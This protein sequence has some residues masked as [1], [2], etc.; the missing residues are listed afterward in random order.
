VVVESNQIVKPI[1][2]GP[3]R[4]FRRL[5]ADE[6][7]L[8]FEGSTIT[9]P[10]RG[11]RSA[12]DPWMEEDIKLKAFMRLEV[13]APYRNNLGTREFQ[14]IIRDW[15][16]HGKSPMLNRLFY[17][18]PRGKWTG[19]HFRPAVVTFNVANTYV[20]EGDDGRNIFG[21][22]RNLEIRNLTS[23]HLRSWTQ[24]PQT[25]MGLVYG[26]PANRIYWQIVDISKFTAEERKPFQDFSEG[27]APLLVFYKSPVVRFN[28]LEV[29]FDLRDQRTVAESLLAIA[30]QTGEG[31][32]AAGATFVAQALSSAQFE[33]VQL[34]GN[35]VVSPLDRPRTGLELRWELAPGVRG[36]ND[37]KKFVGKSGAIRIVAPS[38]SLGVSEV[39]PRLGDPSDSADFPARITYAI[40]YNIFL[41]KERFV[42]D[43]AGIAI[44][45]GAEEIPPR[46][47]TVAFDKP[48]IG[49]VLQHFLE[50][51][52]GHC[53]GMHEIS[54]LEYR[55]G[56]NFCRYWRQVPLDP[57]STAF[58]DYDPSTY[59]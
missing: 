58:Q 16:L 46:D 57:L 18:D 5:N 25:E 2:S 19:T 41:N 52:P 12:A 48:H 11:R 53:T 29:E 50:F 8:E 6:S 13:F 39:A 44:A 38:R 34:P 27:D 40:N 23:H 32:R 21:P 15:D 4:T 17:D 56:V 54:E 22:E 43:Q 26:L 47:V 51:G 9:I 30:K 14:F 37:L 33:I 10:M 49:Q 31:Q 3:Y 55:I 20:T 42:E 28:G 1:Q 35:T 36:F 24:H 45:A 7:F 59:Y